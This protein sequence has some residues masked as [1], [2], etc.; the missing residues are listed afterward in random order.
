MSPQ[1]DDPSAAA[2][3]ARPTNLA[4]IIAFWLFVSIPL[5]WGVWETL[6]KAAQMF[7]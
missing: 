3:E 2:T 7:K 4:T 1:H 6:V 5:G